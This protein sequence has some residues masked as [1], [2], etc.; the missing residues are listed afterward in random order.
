M[1]DWKFIAAEADEEYPGMERLLFSRARHLELKGGGQARYFHLL[2]RGE[3]WA[4][5]SFQIRDKTAI[6]PI[7]APYSGFQ[8]NHGLTLLELNN[9]IG[10]VEESLKKEAVSSIVVRSL[11]EGLPTYPTAMSN[12]LLVDRGYRISESQLHAILDISGPF[13]SNFD[14]NYR[15]KME[16]CSHLTFSWE[17]A[18]NSASIHEF[19][20]KC[21]D[22]RGQGFS[23]GL[24]DFQNHMNSLPD[25]F[26]VAS[27][28]D[29]GKLAAVMTLIRVDSKIS[30]DFAHAHSREYDSISPIIRLTR[31]VGEELAKTGIRFHDLGS[32]SLEGAPNYSLFDFKQ[33]LGSCFCRKDSFEKVL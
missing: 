12:Y 8:L 24:E 18:E 17:T 15:R 7:Y 10:E 14:H 30:Y 23:M 33:N 27:L 28:R 3:L 9:F 11:P 6:S 13:T 32:S 1:G 19:I 31:E 4:S 2:K 29:N 25:D 20:L 16:R 26:L 22:E 5:V 21:R